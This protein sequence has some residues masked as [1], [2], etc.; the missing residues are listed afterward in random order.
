MTDPAQL[1]MSRTRGD[2]LHPRLGAYIEEWHNDLL[3]FGNIGHAGK[4]NV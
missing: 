1:R 3:L 4:P 2:Q